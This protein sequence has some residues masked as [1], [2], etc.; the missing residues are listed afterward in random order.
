MEIKLT[1]A[2]KEAI[3]LSREQN[4][5]LKVDLTKA[6]CCSYGF[7]FSPGSPK[8]DDVMVETEDHLK[9]PVSHE[10]HQFLTRIIIDYR[11]RGLRKAFRV[12]P[13]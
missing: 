2:S 13:N 1:T 8:D 7:V 4:Q 5:Y 12:I 6:G 3:L 10:A 9:I 11:R